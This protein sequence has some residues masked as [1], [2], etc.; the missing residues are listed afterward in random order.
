MMAPKKLSLTLHEAGALCSRFCCTYAGA[1]TL[2]YSCGFAVSEPTC[3]AVKH[4]NLTQ[5]LT[6]TVYTAAF[7]HSNRTVYV[8]VPI[9]ADTAVYIGTEAPSMMPDF[10][11]DQGWDII[12]SAV[13][14]SSCVL[15]SKDLSGTMITGK[16]I[17][18]E[19]THR[20]ID[21]HQRHGL[22]VRQN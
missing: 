10:S 11:F 19:N 21:R 5:S 6:G 18:L 8:N 1:C 16:V 3:L 17:G 2:Q 9:L 12:K 7:W 13:N 4:L 22:Q 20:P 15:H 14:G